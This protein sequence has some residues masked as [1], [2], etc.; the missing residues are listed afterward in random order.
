MFEQSLL[1]SEHLLLHS[2]FSFN[3]AYEIKS[4]Y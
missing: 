3:W 4:A 2:Y 1:K